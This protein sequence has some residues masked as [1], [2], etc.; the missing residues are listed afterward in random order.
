MKGKD[1]TE[2]KVQ[3][4]FSEQFMKLYNEFQSPPSIETIRMANDAFL[5]TFKTIPKKVNKHLPKRVR[6]LQFQAVNNVTIVDLQQFRNCKFFRESILNYYSTLMD[7]F[8]AV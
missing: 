8:V 6:D 1:H 2:T 4:L 3:A 5:K 7:I